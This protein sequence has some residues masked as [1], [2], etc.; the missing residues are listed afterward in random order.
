MNEIKTVIEQGGPLVLAIVALNIIGKMLKT[1]DWHPD[2]LIPIT[3]P[4]LGA[5]IWLFIGDMMPI[6][7][8]TSAEHPQVVHAMIGLTC[9]AF[10]VWGNQVLRQVTSAKSEPEGPTT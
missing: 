4:I 8:I 9:G 5:V 2:K 7:W 3:L 10:A 6:S 1:F